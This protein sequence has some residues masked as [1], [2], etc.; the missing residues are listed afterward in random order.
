[1]A[2]ARTA[3][4]ARLPHV[5]ALDGLRAFAVAGVLLYH[6]GA[7]W[8]PGGF[9]GVD[10][11]FVLSGYLITS[12]L[13]AEW[14]SSGRIDLKR[15]WLRRARRLLPAAVLVIGVSL[16]VAAV[17]LPGDAARMRGDALASLLYVNN[18]HAILADQSYFAAFE[19]PSL[20]QH[21]WSLAVEEQFY[22]LW[23][24][25]LGG[26]LVLLGRARL[27]GAIAALALASALLMAWI[28]APGDDPTRV[29][30]GTDTH[31]LPLLAGAPVSSSMSSPRC[32]SW[33]CWRR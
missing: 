8:M 28:H 30:F 19:R 20:L 23:P 33:D 15:F 11:F 18:W 24:I 32:R 1:M 12:L 10:V 7:A 6:G 22:L 9:L 5:P 31:A 21:L 2:R 26:G 14:T 29:Y 3:S 16:A 17:F 27:V 13:L 25:A 4:S